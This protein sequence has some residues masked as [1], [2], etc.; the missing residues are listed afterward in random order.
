MVDSYVLVFAGLLLTMGTIGDPIERARALV[1]GLVIFGTGS[2]YA[3]I[4]DTA[5]ALIEA[6]T[7]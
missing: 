6:R 3:A 7:R 4:T 2:A 5:G 1:D